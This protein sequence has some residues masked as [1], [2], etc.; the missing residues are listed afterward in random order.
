M[1]FPQFSRIF[2]DRV[3]CIILGEI[4]ARSFLIV[5]PFSLFFPYRVLLIA[6]DATFFFF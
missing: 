6:I 1:N 4:D 3:Q 5:F 2:E